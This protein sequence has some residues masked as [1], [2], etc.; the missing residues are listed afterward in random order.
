M[1]PNTPLEQ[2]M[3]AFDQLVKQGKVRAIGASNYSADAL[4]EAL[5]V[6][7]AKGLA[8]YESLQPHYNLYERTSFEEQLQPLCVKENI[9]VIPYFSLASGF[10]TGKYRSE[11]DFSKSGAAR[12]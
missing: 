3:G 12:E 10:L 8:R 1:I 6:S 11:K 5:A 4:S 9:G 2:T 7:K